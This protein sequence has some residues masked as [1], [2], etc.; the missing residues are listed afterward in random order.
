MAEPAATVPILASERI[1]AT[2]FKFSIFRDITAP[3][4]GVSRSTKETDP[5]P[6][7]KEALQQ[8]QKSLEKPLQGGK[9]EEKRKSER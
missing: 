3:P 7:K 9:K 1:K 2:E 4:A 6:D 5:F 8:S